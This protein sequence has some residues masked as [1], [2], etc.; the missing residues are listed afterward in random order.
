MT[1][2]TTSWLDASAMTLWQCWTTLGRRTTFFATA[3]AVH[4]NGYVSEA[5]TQRY[6][7][8]RAAH[9]T[10]LCLSI[11]PI[12]DVQP[13]TYVTVAWNRLLEVPP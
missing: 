4:Y 8:P 2:D 13:G 7:E 9:L 10:H 3:W 11:M 5:K 1:A 6:A 12:H